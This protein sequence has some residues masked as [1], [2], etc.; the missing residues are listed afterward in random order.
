MAE[1]DYLTCDEHLYEQK[2]PNR[3]REQVIDEILTL[4]CPKCKRAFLDF[5]GCFAVK[6][7][8]CSCGFCGWCLK[9]C[10]VDAHSHVIACPSAETSCKGSYYG[11]QEQF[12]ES[13]RKRQQKELKMFFE[14]LGS[15]EEREALLA[16]MEHDFRDLN[17]T[18]YL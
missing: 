15:S 14:S 2:A 3:L 4:K 7:S 9:D 17:L 16:D 12:K 8:N 1:H 18:V 10:G 11:T 6:C 5:D 13:N